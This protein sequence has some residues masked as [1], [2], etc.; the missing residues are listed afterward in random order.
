[1]MH[2]AWSN[3]EE[4]PYYFLMLS[5]KFQGHTGQK[6][7]DFDP[8]WAFPECKLFEFTDGYK[9]MHKAWSNIEEV[10]YYFLRLSMKFQGHTGQKI[11]DLDPN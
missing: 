2:K 7:A 11:A 4:V 8:N 5:M 6:I 1:M 10:P 9:M 3:I